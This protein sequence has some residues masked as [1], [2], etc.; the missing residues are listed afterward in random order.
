MRGIEA[1]ISTHRKLESAGEQRSRKHLSCSRNVASGE[2]IVPVFEPLELL[3]IGHLVVPSINVIRPE[4]RS[5]DGLV[6]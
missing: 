5:F 3:G 2:P 1:C 4:I 6:D